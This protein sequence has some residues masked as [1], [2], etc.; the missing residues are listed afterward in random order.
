MKLAIYSI[1]AL[2]GIG[3]GKQVLICTINHKLTLQDFFVVYCD[4]SSN[5]FVDQLIDALQKRKNF[6]P[7]HIK[8][9]RSQFDKKI[10]LIEVKG[11]I[12]DH[13]TII[14]LYLQVM[15]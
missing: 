9:H 5:K 11:M 7:L 13:S 15:I 2:L 1:V 6:D 14:C 3:L 10:G 4:E 12:V 8:D